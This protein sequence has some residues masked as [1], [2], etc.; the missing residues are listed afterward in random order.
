MQVKCPAI[1]AVPAGMPGET[2]FSEIEI[3]PDS[4]AWPTRMEPVVWPA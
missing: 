1:T 2:F 3:L 4:A